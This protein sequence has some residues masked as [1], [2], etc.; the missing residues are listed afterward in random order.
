MILA[1][2]HK[3]NELFFPHVAGGRE[4]SPVPSNSIAQD[5]FGRGLV[6]SVIEEPRFL[7]L[8]PHKIPVQALPI[9][10]DTPFP[11]V[12]V[13]QP[14]NHGTSFRISTLVNRSNSHLVTSPL[15]FDQSPT[16]RVA[17]VRHILKSLSDYFRAYY[18][19]NLVQDLQGGLFRI[20]GEQSARIFTQFGDQITGQLPGC[21]VGEQL[22]LHERDDINALLFIPQFTEP[23]PVFGQSL[24]GHPQSVMRH[25]QS[26][27]GAVIGAHFD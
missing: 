26:V 14:E 2:P 5:F 9:N 6:T 4:Q 21:I 27:R 7:H 18:S 13:M 16:N 3:L 24:F 10:E 1:G 11:S 20:E 22:L 8:T 12:L 19:Q 15:L 23:V 25:V 17:F